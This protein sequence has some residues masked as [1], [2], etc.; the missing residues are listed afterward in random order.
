[1]P[2]KHARPAARIR[3]AKLKAKMQVRSDA[4][5]RPSGPRTIAIAHP[6]LGLAALLTSLLRRSK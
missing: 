5:K 3:R 1:M 4:V 6:G 2:R